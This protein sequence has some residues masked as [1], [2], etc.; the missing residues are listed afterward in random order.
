MIIIEKVLEYVCRAIL[1]FYSIIM[2][3]LVFAF[4]STIY[5][6]DG[7]SAIFLGAAA[8]LV[9][10]NIV[11]NKYILNINVYSLMCIIGFFL[12]GSYFLIYLEI[13]RLPSLEAFLLG[14]VQPSCF[15][16][17]WLRNRG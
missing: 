11:R 17:L 9:G 15:I 13:G 12:S 8:I 16:I 2:T 1:V 4:H 10:F 7:L 14:M 5:F 3:F 6:W